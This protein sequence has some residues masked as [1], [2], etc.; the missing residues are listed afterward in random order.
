MNE[1]ID[2][3]LAAAIAHDGVIVRVISS[4]ASTIVRAW[5]TSAVR[6]LWQPAAETVRPLTAVDRLRY[7]CVALAAAV[8]TRLLLLLL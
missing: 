7:G 2:D 8:V 4:S 6:R 1:S 3:R 5:H